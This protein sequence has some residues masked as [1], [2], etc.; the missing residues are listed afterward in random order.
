MSKLLTKRKQTSKSKKLS[1]RPR[2]DLYDIKYDT[3]YANTYADSPILPPTLLP[4]NLM[5]SWH[6]R[7]LKSLNG[8]QRQRKLNFKPNKISDPVMNNLNIIADKITDSQTIFIL[9][10]E[11]L[12][13]VYSK[14]TKKLKEAQGSRK[15]RRF[16]NRDNNQF[17][18]NQRKYHDDWY[19]KLPG[20]QPHS[21][22]KGNA[23]K[24]SNMKYYVTEKSDGI[25]MMMLFCNKTDNVYFVDRKFTF[26]R[27]KH[28]FYSKY[29]RYV[30]VFE[31]ELGIFI[32]LFEWLKHSY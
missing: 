29:L 25:R 3:I 1:K 14:D 2:R 6:E 20:P 28:E 13:K 30:F 17:I 21:L 22:S 5:V 26:Y 10:D 9:K 7:A 23:I 11:I 8:F 18:S 32:S 19:K 15:Y 24:L 4:K 27:V 12:Q 16:N 31:N